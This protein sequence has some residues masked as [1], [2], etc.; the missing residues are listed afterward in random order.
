MNPIT[1][2]GDARP[3]TSGGMEGQ[4]IAGK[5]QLL[6]L[7]GQGGMGA[8]Y[9]GRNAATLKRCAVKLL[10]SAELGANE[11][12]IKR[13]FRE[14]KA[15]SVIESDHVV[16]IYDSGV[17]PAVGAPYMVMELLQGEDLEHT[18]KRLG[19]VHPTTAA[20]LVLQAA[21]GL[22]KA[23]ELHIVHR[24]IKPANLYLTRRDTGDLVVKLLDFGIAKVKMESFAET[25]HGLT[26]TGSMLGTPLYMSPEQAKGAAN[27]DARS[28]VWSLGMVLYELLSGGLPFE[29]ASSLGELMVSIIT[30]DIPLLQDKAPWVPPEL[31]EVCHRAISRDVAK[32]FQNAG[33]F[34]DALAAI[35]PDGPRL[36]EDMLAP[37]PV[38]YRSYVAPRLQLT[39][40][41]MLRATTRTGLARTA[42]SLP[43]RPKRSPAAVIAVAV[44]G[45]VLVGGGGAVAFTVTRPAPEPVTQVVTQT[46]VVPGQPQVV[47]APSAQPVTFA[48][49]VAPADAEIAVDGKP[50]T[51]SEGKL[52][53]TGRPGEA[54]K[55]TLSAAGQSQE[56]T[57]AV[58]EGGLVPSKVTLDAKRA[59]V[60]GAGRAGAAQPRAGAETKPAAAEDKP[61]APPKKAAPVVDKG[62]KEFD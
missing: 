12:V 29:N 9:E 60:A 19:A 35:T 47:A 18:L 8:V 22:A 26:R 3:P 5:Y 23:H 49:E 38:A 16:T 48:L 17:D 27:I 36:V 14:A 10:I 51:L 40:D 13:F 1:Q 4:V 15:S 34:R 45:V 53:L 56:F 50:A 58:T 41:G 39:D 2:D 32:R 59:A 55:V 46:V 42:A 7:L 43:P 37:V 62:T 28:D 44:A 61:A 21:M 24:D 33:E 57:V 30:A 20:K 54:K 31:A 11:Q 6:R 25:S 52:Q